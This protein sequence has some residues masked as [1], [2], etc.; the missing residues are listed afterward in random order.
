MIAALE[1]KRMNGAGSSR[2]QG[3]AEDP[4]DCRYQPN[5]REKGE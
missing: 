3:E 4:G 1:L 2:E 5:Y